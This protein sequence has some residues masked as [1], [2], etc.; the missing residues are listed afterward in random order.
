MLSLIKKRLVKDLNLLIIVFIHGLLLRLSLK[1]N[2]TINLLMF[3]IKTKFINQVCHPTEKGNRE[4]KKI[5]FL[6][7]LLPRQNRNVK[8]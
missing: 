7:F 4:R 8:N 3:C 1:Y 6:P 5:F 2:T